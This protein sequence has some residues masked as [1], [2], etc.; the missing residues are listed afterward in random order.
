[1]LLQFIYTFFYAMTSINAWFCWVL[2]IWRYKVCI[3]SFYHVFSSLLFPEQSRLAI[4]LGDCL[5]KYFQSFG[6][7]QNICFVYKLEKAPVYLFTFQYKEFSFLKVPFVT[8]K[9]S[10]LLSSSLE[11]IMECNTG[12]IKTMLLSSCCSDYQKEKMV[13]SQRDILQTQNVLHSF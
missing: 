10:I 13:L 1:M 9:K 6:A 4:K 7:I 3:L 2:S 5:L 11:G 12:N 8:R